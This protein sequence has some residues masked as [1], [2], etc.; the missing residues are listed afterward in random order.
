[1]RIVHLN[2]PLAMKILDRPPPAE[3]NANHVLQRAG[4]EEILLLQAEA[5]ALEAFIVG[6]QDFR[7]VLREHLLSDRTLIIASVEAVKVEGFGGFRR[8]KPQ[9][10]RSMFAV[11]QN[12]SVI[13]NTVHDDVR[14]PAHMIFSV[15]APSRLRVAAE[16]DSYDRFRTPNL[17]RVSVA[18]P[19]IGDFD[20]PSVAN[21]LVKNPE[22]I[23][24]AV[25]DRRNTQRSQRVQVA[26]GEAAQST[27][28]QSGL[29]FLGNDFV[30]VETQFFRSLRDRFLY[31]EVENIISKMWAYQ[32][33]GGEVGHDPGI[34]LKISF[35]RL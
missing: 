8:P 29:F 34:L 14:N 2:R 13:G 26:G 5:L 22:F 20:L 33:L 15:G 24:D 25:A 28:S 32:K 21:F 27:V 1:M 17:P 31:L 4:D 12:R 16:T 19:L 18:Q 35:E 6:I 3:M 10:I 11:S 9:I 23:S 7:N 30:Q